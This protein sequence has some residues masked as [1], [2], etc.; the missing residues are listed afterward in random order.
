MCP[1]RG[2]AMRHAGRM[3][4]AVRTT[5]IYCRSGCSATPLPRNVVPYRH[6]AAA[7]ADGF[8]ACHRCRP[9]R[10]ADIWTANSELVCRSMQ[11]ILDGAL[12]DAGE[13]ALA[14]RV[15]ASAR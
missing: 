13:S 2:P 4:S 12:D 3:Y 6:T 5:G 1:T 11:L 10:G 7:E 14:A 15:G 8:R 9:Y